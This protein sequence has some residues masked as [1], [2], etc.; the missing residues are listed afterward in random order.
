ML[1]NHLNPS[2]VLAAQNWRTLP[3]LSRPSIL[4]KALS[5]ITGET[6]SISSTSTWLKFRPIILD[7]FSNKANPSIHYN[8]TAKE[9]WDSVAEDHKDLVLIKNG[10]NE[11]ASDLAEDEGINLFSAACYL[12][13]NGFLVAVKISDTK[14]SP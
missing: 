11:A 6:T 7:Q 3:A 13:F 4:G 14:P 2:G 9:I 12:M 1:Y 10:A 8:T 5:A